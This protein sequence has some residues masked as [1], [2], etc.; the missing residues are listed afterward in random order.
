MSLCALAVVLFT[1]AI[2]GVPQGT[3]EGAA[4]H[5]W[6]VLIA[7]QL[8]LLVFFLV[9]WLPRAPRQTLCV[10]LLQIGAVVAAMAPV[11]LLHL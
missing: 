2:F 6:Q 8:P 5:I 11:F 7:G 4:A 3:D 10:I 9:K 1:I